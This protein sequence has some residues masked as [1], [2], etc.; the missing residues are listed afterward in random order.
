MPR[1]AGPGTRD[2]RTTKDDSR[3]FLDENEAVKYKL[4][5]ARCNYLVPDRLDM[6]YAVKG[7]AGAMATP[8][9]GDME[10]IKR[11]GR[12]LRGKPRFIQWFEWQP[13]VETVVAYSDVDRAGCK[14]TRKST[15]G[16]CIFIGKHIFK[17]WSN[18]QSL[19][20][21]ISGES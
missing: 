17:V 16:G 20:A 8:C 4:I 13:A 14:T 2:E 5:V 15:I 10:R 1:C 6:A 11:L 3:T 21:L 18:I 12:Y 19:M 9:E 7:L